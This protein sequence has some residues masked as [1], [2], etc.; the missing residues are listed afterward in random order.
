[1]LGQDVREAV[2]SPDFFKDSAGVQTSIFL[3]HVLQQRN[4]GG[5]LLLGHSLGEI[6]ALHLAGCFDF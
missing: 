3:Y 1:M 5:D 6:A 4:W 2:K